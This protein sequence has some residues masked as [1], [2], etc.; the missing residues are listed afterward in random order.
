MYKKRQ[1][2]PKVSLITQPVGAWNYI[3]MVNEH[4]KINELKTLIYKFSQDSTCYSLFLETC[5]WFLSIILDS[6]TS[7]TCQWYKLVV[8][9]QNSLINVMKKTQCICR[10][11]LKAFC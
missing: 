8:F 6:L 9:G 7:I 3:S 4:T 5:N 10:D 1:T 2:A 11:L